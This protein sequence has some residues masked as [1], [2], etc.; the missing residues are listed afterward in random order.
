MN[1]PPAATVNAPPHTHTHTLTPPSEGVSR[2]GDTS[3]VEPPQIPFTQ[4]V[5]SLLCCVTASHKVRSSSVPPSL[6]P[7]T[8]RFSAL[9]LSLSP[10][11]RLRQLIR[12][13]GP[14]CQLASSWR[15]QQPRD[16]A[17]YRTPV[18]KPRQHCQRLHQLT[19]TSLALFT[20]V[21]KHQRQNQDSCRKQEQEPHDAM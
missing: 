9:A 6:S 17:P 8:H 11:S 21:T 3:S 13:L 15:A 5:D 1:P 7:P 10:L 18:H 16:L 14:A 19:R 12:R 2:L 20:R 4:F